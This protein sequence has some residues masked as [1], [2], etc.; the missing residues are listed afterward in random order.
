MPTAKTSVLVRDVTKAAVKAI[1][2]LS[3]GNYTI[4]PSSPP[5]FADSDAERL[6]HQWLGEELAQQIDWKD[7]AKRAQQ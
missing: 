1:R 7:F 2:Q 4:N 5:D 3:Y 6:F